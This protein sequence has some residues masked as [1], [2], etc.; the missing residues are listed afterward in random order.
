MDDFGSGLG[1]LLSLRHVPFAAIKLSGPLIA[2]ASCNDGTRTV[3]DGL[4]R[5]AR[6]LRMHVIA[7][8]VDNMP[9]LRVLQ[10]SGVRAAQG[11]LL[12]RPEPLEA[13]LGE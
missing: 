10:D 9:Q 4:V 6:G 5:M 8:E 11:Y 2:H 7:E 3:L 1:S 13:L 12:G